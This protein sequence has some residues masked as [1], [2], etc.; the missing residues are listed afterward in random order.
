[1]SAKSGSDTFGDGAAFIDLNG[2]ICAPD[3]CLAVINGVLVF[4]DGTHLTATFVR[5]LEK[6]LEKEL[7]SLL[8]GPENDG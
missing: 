4:R 8:S 1:L 5:T 3:R 7:L 2:L 6:P